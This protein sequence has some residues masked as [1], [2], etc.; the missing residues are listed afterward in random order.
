MH[1]L[2]YHV[3]LSRPSIILHLIISNSFP[4]YQAYIMHLPKLHAKSNPD[5]SHAAPE[6]ISSTSKSKSSSSS[7][8]DTSNQQ[9]PPYSADP[10]SQLPDTSAFLK[11]PVHPEYSNDLPAFER[12]TRDRETDAKLAAKAKG[13]K[14]S[15]PPCRKVECISDK[16]KALHENRICINTFAGQKREW[17]WYRVCL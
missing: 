5:T 9:P 10:P 14:R 8:Q 12:D 1:R 11:D 4:Q 3:H 17:A 15:V 13:D 2:V 16:R 7:H 6:I